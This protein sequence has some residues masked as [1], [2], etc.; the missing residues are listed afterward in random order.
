MDIESASETPAL[1]D[2]SDAPVLSVII[3]VWNRPD[4]L[5]KCLQSLRAQTLAPEK[6]EII[7][8]DNGSEDETPEIARGFGVTLLVE[9]RSGSYAAR[10]LGLS[11]ARGTYVAFIDSDCRADARWLEAGLD[12]IHAHPNAGVVAGQIAL[13]VDDDKASTSV[14]AAYERIF[15][16]NQAKNV[17]KGIA[18]TANWFARLDLMRN[19]GGFRPDLKSG[20]DTELSRRISRGGRSIVYA[21][22]ANVFHPARVTFLDLASKARRVL[23]GRMIAKGNRHALSYW[24]VH[25]I[26][27]A[28]HRVRNAWRT[29]QLATG[30]KMKVTLLSLGLMFIGMAEVV[31]LAAGAEPRRD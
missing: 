19:M 15:S 8:V 7:V 18:V 12:A 2:S 27:A 1:T 16:F 25:V 17:T 23:G 28:G 24:L 14:C 20:G 22:D 4:D 21:P 29:D 10:T 11:R 30:M 9:N 5:R 3:P 31:R 6:Y 13:E 26:R